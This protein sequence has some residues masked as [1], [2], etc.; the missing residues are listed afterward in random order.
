M[1][2][3]QWN[4]QTALFDTESAWSPTGT[5][6]TNDIASLAGWT[7][8]TVAEIGGRTV[9]GLVL[10]NSAATLTVNGV[11]SS[12]AAIDIQAGRITVGATG[13]LL[14]ATTIRNAG[15]INVAAGQTLTLGASAIT[16]AG[17]I[18]VSGGT[19]LIPPVFTIAQALRSVIGLSNTGQIA[20]TNGGTLD[21]TAKALS[22]A[23]LTAGAISVDQSSVVALSGAL[24]LGGAAVNFRSGSVL[25]QVSFRGE[26]LVNGTV[27]GTGAVFG[28]S[29]LTLSHIT[30]TGSWTLP[31]G[32]SLWADATSTF[33][34]GTVTIA[35]GASLLDT[36]ILDGLTI[37]LG[38]AGA[39]GTATLAGTILAGGANF[40]VGPTIGAG[41]T[42]V[43]NGRATLGLAHNFGMILVQSGTLTLSGN[44]HNPAD[45]AGYVPLQAIN[46]GS[47]IVSGGLLRLDSFSDYQP[48]TAVATGQIIIGNRG[49]A[50]V[51]FTSTQASTATN[52]NI[53][54]ADGTG[55]LVLA[56]KAGAQSWATIAVSGFVG[57]DSIIAVNGSGSRFD[58]MSQTLTFFDP[59]SGQSLA[60]VVFASGH[61]VAAGDLLGLGGAN[62]STSVIAAANVLLPFTPGTRQWLGETGNFGDASRWTP[63]GVPGPTDTASVAGTVAYVAT[64]SGTD[65]VGALALNNTL[66]TLTVAGSLTATG[67]LVLQNGVLYIPGTLRNTVVSQSGGSLLASS[68]G[69]L[70]G[71]TWVGDL[72]VS[73]GITIRNGLTLYGTDGTSAGRM[74]VASG[75]V[76][77]ADQATIDLATIQLCSTLIAAAGLTLGT[78]AIL[79][80][81][82]GSTQLLVTGSLINA[83]QILVSSGRLELGGSKTTRFINS[84]SINVGANAELDLTAGTT[85]LAELL[86]GGL[87]VDPAGTLVLEGTLDLGGAS[88]DFRSGSA[89]AGA[90]LRGATLANGIVDATGGNFSFSTLALRNVVWRGPLTLAANATL[91]ADATDRFLDATGSLAGSIDLSSAAA[92]LASSGLL[93]NILINLGNATSPAAIVGANLVFP[94][95]Q[96]RLT[97]PSLG[98]DATI[99]ADGFASLELTRNQG[100]VIAQSSTLSLTGAAGVL[101]NA[102]IVRTAGALLIAGGLNDY[103]AGNPIPVGQTQIGNGGIFKLIDATGITSSHLNVKFIDNNGTLEIATHPATASDTIT[104]SGWVAGAVITADF[105]DTAQFVAATNSL[106]FSSSAAPGEFIT[107]NLGAAHIYSASELIGLGTR[108]VTT[109]FVAGPVTN[110]FPPATPTTPQ[111]LGVSGSFGDANLWTPTGVPDASAIASLAGTA[112]YVVNQSGSQAVGGLVVANGQATITIGGTL[113]ASTLSLQAGTLNLVGTL[114]NTSVTAAGGALIASG[115]TLDNVGWRGEL[116][117]AGTLTVRNG[118]VLR[119]YDGSLAGHATIQGG[120]VNFANSETLD[121]VAITLG[122]NLSGAEALGLGNRTALVAQGNATLVAGTTLNTAG[123]VTVGAGNT[124][125]IGTVM[126]FTPGTLVNSGIIAV[127]SGTLVVQGGVRNSGTIQ[128]SNSGEI[129]FASTSLT[130][131][132][133][134]AIAADASSRVVISGTFDLGGGTVDF[135][136]GSPLAAAVFNDATLINGHVD[137]RRGS[138]HGTLAALTNVEWRGPITIAN[139][140]SLL[141][142]SATR[143]VDTADPTLPG[144]VA[145]SG[146][147]Q[148]RN[149]GT[150]DA[151]QINLGDM[152]STPVATL[153]GGVAI[154]GTLQDPVI[155][156]SATIVTNNNARISFARNIGTIIAQSGT[157]VLAG[158]SSGGNDFGTVIDTGATILASAYTNYVGSS[159][160]P[161]GQISL[162][163]GSVFTAINPAT[164]GQFGIAPGVHARIVFADASGTVAVQ[165][166]TISDPSQFPSIY[167][168]PTKLAVAGFQAGDVISVSAGT[169]RFDAKANELTFFDS[170]TDTTSAV[171]DFESGHLFDPSEF[172]GLGST[173]VTTSFT[174]SGGITAC[175]AAG[176]RIITPTGPVAVEGLQVGDLVITLD[177]SHAPIIW[178]GHRNLECGRHPR[179]HDVRPMRVQQGAFGAAP[180]GDLWL[181]PDH[182]IFVDDMLVPVRYLENGATIRQEEAADVTYWHIELVRHAVIRAEGLPC[183]TY[184]D[185]GNRHAFVEGGPSVQLHPEFARAVWKREGCARLVTDSAG[186]SGVRE[187]LAAQA[188]DLGYSTTDEPDLHVAFAGIRL[189]GVR[190]GDAWHFNIPAPGAAEIRSRHARP[191]DTD[192]TSADGRKLGVAIA[193]VWLNGRAVEFGTG[194]GWLPREEG[195]C[196]TNGRA[197]LPVTDIG[198]LTI[199][200]ALAPR[201][202]LAP[203][204]EWRKVA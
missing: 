58:A 142:D 149:N 48:G 181:S 101:N 98:P 194:S 42:V 16:N 106:Q 46:Q 93:D 32:M 110:I 165:A 182:A 8:Y 3:K 29:A 146:G 196:W 9:G 6:G 158:R 145:I 99:L 23:S 65:I 179:P 129:D 100:T 1:T 54:F 36:G 193:A 180:T 72:T 74:I 45:P 201:F 86:A 78:H 136:P 22:W 173:S 4:G 131:L 20:L 112:A 148:V 127:N 57:G 191:I 114:R 190:V 76:T 171:I 159:V 144:A 21:I 128:V 150:I 39:I 71:V 85:S 77:I 49:T 130:N 5:P 11:L 91:T 187:M 203:A 147:G 183:E 59:T 122:G 140:Q 79:Q 195:W 176:T 109:D 143:F 92:T 47:I 170:S 188:R 94:G 87:S 169:A 139:G 113:T 161:T 137:A 135:G 151:V 184:L 52:A 162:A 50:E 14:A 81:G 125:T 25:N 89:L 62:V 56:T 111:W 200:V 138:F 41:A 13:S 132:R 154:F 63:S 105:A 31:T 121:N 68:S 153:W 199:V 64:Q 172:L 126:G 123:S 75:S 115:G 107:V 197:A 133:A 12:T 116:L 27:D 163:N 61:R 67:G 53:I 69:T 80:T 174:G 119:A 60:T 117:V 90:L 198:V 33:S 177:G 157:L 30:W 43:V 66:A 83:G 37:A 51:D 28:G 26:T 55:T 102:G 120:S 155:G 192:P 24:E 84:G 168:V 70:D 189:D 108:I 152:T 88:L 175:F 44:A 95:G 35:P 97:P 204:S 186:L 178:L 7:G 103:Q 185:T 118:L 134:A 10:A 17:L 34:L 167:S 19:V 15:T 160:I 104:V 141:V 164:A 40:V 156:S 38:H 73:S 18:S 124:L 202:W 2:T 96:G 82:S 166:N